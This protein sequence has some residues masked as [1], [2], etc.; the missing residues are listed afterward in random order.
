V[1][2]ALVLLAAAGCREPA[3]AVIG[4]AMG[5]DTLML[6]RVLASRQQR[7]NDS[8]GPQRQVRL[9]YASNG[10]GASSTQ[11]L[12]WAGDLVGTP[13]LAGVVG[14]E[15]SRTALLA[16]P[17]Y[18]KHGVVQIVPTGTSTRLT[19]VSPWT[20]A[21]VASDSSQGELLARQLIATHSRYVTLFVQDD[22][23]GRGVVAALQRAIAG[24]DI[25]ILDNVVQTQDSDHEL[26]VRSVLN[27]TPAPDA[28]VLITQGG[29]AVRVATLAWARQPSLL[30]L[31]SDA[32]STEAAALRTLAPAPDRL[33]FVTYWLPDSTQAATRAFLREY[34]SSGTPP[35]EA[36][37]YHAAIYDAVGLLNAAMAEA[38]NSPGAVRGWLLSLGRS[39]AAYKGVLGAIDFTGQHAIPA[40]LIRPSPSGWEPVP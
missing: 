7:F 23:Y 33:A 16:A 15:S 21:L 6:Q 30:I 19:G 5:G 2:V 24:H 17:V 18:G 3:P 32:V 31:G 37:W 1:A 22:E 28:L 35:E 29:I 13:G 36:Q 25:Q 10:A 14:H 40:R 39:H 34:Q 12:K 38:G 8:V 26:L 11:A 27:H 9:L 4:I 20:F